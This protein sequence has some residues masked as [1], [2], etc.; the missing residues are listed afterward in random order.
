MSANF[1]NAAKIF[2]EI[3]ALKAGPRNA[4]CYAIKS[5]LIGG[6]CQDFLATLRAYIKGYSGCFVNI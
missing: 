1:A 3:A 6:I 2:M 4:R 5:S